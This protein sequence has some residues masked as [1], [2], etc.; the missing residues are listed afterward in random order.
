MEFSSPI[1][2]SAELTPTPQFP[3][4]P[5]HLIVRYPSGIEPQA[6]FHLRRRIRALHHQAALSEQKQRLTQVKVERGGEEEFGQSDGRP[7]PPPAPSADSDKATEDVALPPHPSRP[8]ALPLFG[9]SYRIRHFGPR[10]WKGQVEYGL[11]LGIAAVLSGAMTSLITSLSTAPFLTIPYIFPFFAVLVTT[12]KLGQSLSVIL[13][14][15]QGGLVSIFLTWV[16]LKAGLGEGDRWQGGLTI[17]LLAVFCLYV[18]RAQPFAKKG[19][20][21]VIVIVVL[22]AVDYASVR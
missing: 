16:A 7:Q 8:A 13:Q 17:F 19:S 1:A 21:A 4:D 11:R 20:G 10:H 18:F 22:I 14:I 5:S 3:T 6:E 12:Y 15:V 2:P 9:W